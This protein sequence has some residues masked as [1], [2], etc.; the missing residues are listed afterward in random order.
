MTRPNSWRAVLWACLGVGLVARIIGA[1]DDGIFWPDEIYQSFEPA[2]ALVFGHGLIPWEYIDGARTW[3][4][5]GF[6][7]GLL[8]VCAALGLDSPA[9][10][11]RAVKIVFAVLG[12][13]T[14]L[15]VHR[16]A[17]AFGAAEEGAVAA[18]ALWAFA[19]LAVY[20][21]PRA[22]AENACVAPA[23]WGLALLF[24]AKA[25]GPRRVLL[26]S[27]LLGMAV[28][29]RL[30]TALFAAGAVGVLAARREWRALGYALVGLGVWA[31]LYGALDA[32]TWHDA[33][34]ARWGGWFHSA[35]VYVRFNIIE[36]RGANWGTAPWY[37]YP[38]YVFTSMPTVALAL[39]LGVAGA[40]WRRAWAL[41]ALVAL[42]AVVH[43]A[44]PHKEIRFILPALPLAAA[45]VG[46]ALG[47]ARHRA[48]L[49][50]FAV[51]FAVVSLVQTP[52]LTMGQLGAYLNR[53][54]SKAWGDFAPANRLLL[55]ASERADVCGLRVDVA[56]MAWVGGATYLHRP[57]PL[58][59]P[60]QPFEA[61]H[62]NYLLARDG[63][64]QFEKVATDSGLALYRLPWACVPDPGFPWRL[65]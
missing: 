9:F 6:V 52:F 55:V 34:G 48:R 42:F 53:R 50:A 64:T 39:L 65:G 35:V 33:P 25:V 21:S 2:H 15:G 18:A 5:P 41:P 46:V 61:R 31:L 4:L 38:R 28:L 30:Q 54:H 20:F 19:S 11:V 10:Y 44:S 45:C 23:V 26:A 57:A 43:M 36:N 14:A 60:S 8:E 63:L 49:A 59:R 16:L 40:L 7:A 58:Y 62:F 56:D 47:D 12:V 29:L 51:A 1:F 37:F 27:S 32:A 3:A 17:R 13:V 22:M 24:E